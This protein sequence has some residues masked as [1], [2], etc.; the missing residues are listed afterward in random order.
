MGVGLEVITKKEIADD[1]LGIPEKFGLE[2]QVI[3]RCEAGK[4]RN[5]VTI[6]SVYG[7]FQYQ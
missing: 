2:A 3:G 5:H 1:L 7:T 6:R 4:G